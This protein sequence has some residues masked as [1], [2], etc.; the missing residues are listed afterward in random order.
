VDL[1]G[2]RA[3]APREIELS[4]YSVAR[5]ADAR[6]AGVRLPIRDAGSWRFAGR[7]LEVVGGLLPAFG[8]DGVLVGVTEV[9]VGSTSELQGGDREADGGSEG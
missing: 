6:P 2:S 5:V 3:G 7:V 8:F 4:G 1:T 9:L